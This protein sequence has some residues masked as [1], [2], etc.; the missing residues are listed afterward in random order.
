MFTFEPSAASIQAKTVQRNDRKHRRY[1][2]RLEAEKQELSLG[3]MT[4]SQ[5]VQLR[6]NVDLPN[7][8]KAMVIRYLPLHDICNLRIVSKSWSVAGAKQMF[9]NGFYIRPHRDDL[10]R[11]GRVV[12]DPS[13]A[14][15]IESVIIHIGDMGWEFWAYIQDKWHLGPGEFDIIELDSF[16]FSDPKAHCNEVLLRPLLSKLPN[17]VAIT[18]TTFQCPYTAE[19]EEY[20]HF[21]WLTGDHK[22]FSQVISKIRYPSI[23]LAVCLY[24]GF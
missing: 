24:H 1:E 11:L 7:E 13:F 20:G 21:R 17:L 14:K 19:M 5:A 23:L 18:A 16:G 8:L 9:H 3:L 6:K 12:N 2:R 10:G 4:A 15:S 22:G